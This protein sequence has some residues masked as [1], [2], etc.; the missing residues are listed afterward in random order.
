MNIPNDEI[1]VMDIAG[2]YAR[3]HTSSSVHKHNLSAKGFVKEGDHLVLHLRDQRDR[4][5]AV[6]MLIRLGA[7][8]SVGTGWSPAELVEHYREQGLISGSYRI[9]AWKHPGEYLISQR[10]CQPGR[11]HTHRNSP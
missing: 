11:E 10:S 9:I 4:A 8:F 2:A 1:V 3:V 5:T 6:E 7:L